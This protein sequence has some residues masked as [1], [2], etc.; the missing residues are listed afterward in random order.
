MAASRPCA[1]VV[2][3]CAVAGADAALASE[4][5]ARLGLQIHDELL[6]VGLAADA[7]VVSELA[8]RRWLRRLRSVR[9]CRSSGDRRRLAQREIDG[10]AGATERDRSSE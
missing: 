5:R 4:G 2:A 3:R 8:V 7:E 6:F 1:A 10:Y 9:C